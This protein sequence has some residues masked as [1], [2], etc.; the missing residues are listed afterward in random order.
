MIIEEGGKPEE[1]VVSGRAIDEEGS[2]SHAFGGPPK[3][4]NEN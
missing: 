1:L 2:M 4:K 3:M